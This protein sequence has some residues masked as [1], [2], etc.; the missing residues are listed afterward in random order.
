MRLRPVTFKYKP[1]LDPSGTSQYGL[2]AEEVAQVFPDLVGRNKQGQ[3][4]T[5][6]YHLLGALLL[7]ALQKQQH[8][9]QAQAREIR[10]LRAQQNHLAQLASD[11]AALRSRLEQLEQVA[12]HLAAPSG[13]RGRQA[14]RTCRVHE[15]S[16]PPEIG[17][18]A[19]D[20]RV[21]RTKVTQLTSSCL[22][23]ESSRRRRSQHPSCWH[24]ARQRR[25]R[26]QRRDGK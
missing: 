25:N 13:G 20:G 17:Q 9:Q 24:R 4:E 26:P 12:T 8:A 22:A 10:T 6:K 16:L 23:S 1:E 2:I 18:A 3:I 7:N 15:G 14:R 5:V 11:D 21:L 19:V